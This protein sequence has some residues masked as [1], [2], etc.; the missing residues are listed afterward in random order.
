MKPPVERYIRCS[1]TRGDWTVEPGLE[2]CDGD[3]FYSKV[4]DLKV[5]ADAVA[6]LACEGDPIRAAQRG[7]GVF[8]RWW[9]NRA[10]FLEVHATDGSWTQSYQPYGIPRGT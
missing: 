10:W 5:V 2:W 4:G 1:V 9:P 8:A 7:E 3:D 6:A